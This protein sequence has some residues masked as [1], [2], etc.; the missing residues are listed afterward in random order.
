VKTVLCV[1]TDKAGNAIGEAA[2][3]T[4]YTPLSSK[5]NT[6]CTTAGG[7]Y[8]G[9][10]KDVIVPSGQ[11]CALLPSAHVTHDVDV[12]SGGKLVDEGAAVDHDLQADHPAA[13]DV[14]AG[15]TIGHDLTVDGSSGPVSVHG[16]TIGHDLNVLNGTGTVS[17][18]GNTVGHD[19][20]VNNNKP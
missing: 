12:Q 6:N 3:Y 20:N 14:E 16:A 5:G 17:V 19:T 9:T 18:S 11:T 13:I 8:G 7:P 10:G 1:V 2:T 4:V 15:S